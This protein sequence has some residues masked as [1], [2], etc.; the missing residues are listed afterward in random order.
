MPVT[1]VAING[2]NNTQAIIR[3]HRRAPFLARER[4]SNHVP[5]SASVSRLNPTTA[6]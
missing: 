2:G 3:C 4:H 6:V 5:L 1:E